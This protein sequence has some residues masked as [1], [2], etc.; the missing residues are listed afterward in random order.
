[1]IMDQ[2]SM[3]VQLVDQDQEEYKQVTQLQTQT[4]H[5]IPRVQVHLNPLANMDQVKKNKK[6]WLLKY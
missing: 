2:T 1:M 4:Y 3:E 5:K 6:L